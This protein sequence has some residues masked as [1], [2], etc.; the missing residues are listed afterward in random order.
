[1]G[2]KVVMLNEIKKTNIHQYQ[3]DALKKIEKYFSSSGKFPALVKMPTGTGKTGV[4]AVASQI[5][6]DVVLIIVPNSILPEQTLS[7]IQEGFFNKIN[8]KPSRIKEAII[9]DKA[10]MMSKLDYEKNPIL[11]MTIQL[12]AYIAENEEV[13]WKSLK[14]NVK[15]LFLMKDIVSPLNIGVR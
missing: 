7:E 11:I 5:T 14:D 1:M 15:L 12:L 9:I 6:K 10:S 4:M 3:F 8:H 2:E 13:Y